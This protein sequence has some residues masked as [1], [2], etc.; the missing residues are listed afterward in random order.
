MPSLIPAPIPAYCSCQASVGHPFPAV[1]APLDKRIRHVAPSHVMLGVA[2]LNQCLEE[3][4]PS[5]F[6][7]AVTLAPSTPVS[8]MCTVLSVSH[9]THS[10]R[11]TVYL[12]ETA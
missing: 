7:T 12:T 3:T 10:V 5:T 1:P 6:L 11:F 4:F 9:D 8:C 2:V